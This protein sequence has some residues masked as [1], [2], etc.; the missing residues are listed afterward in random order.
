LFFVYTKLAFV[1]G[2]CCLVLK[3][4]RVGGG[5][6]VVDCVVR[7]SSPFAGVVVLLFSSDL[8]FSQKM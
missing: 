6:W 2:C 5:A 7:F 1:F 4:G 8:P 3:G